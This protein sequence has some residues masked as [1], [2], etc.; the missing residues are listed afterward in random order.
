[1]LLDELES[2]R[3]VG[4]VTQE[5]QTPILAVL[6][7]SRIGRLGV[8]YFRS[9]RDSS[10]QNT[11]AFGFSFPWWLFVT[12]IALTDVCRSRDGVA[13]GV[14]FLELKIVDVLVLEREST[15]LV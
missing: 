15:V 3:D 13:I 11:M 12:R 9:V 8:R 14:V 4:L 1:L 6:N 10:A 7:G 2:A 5:Q